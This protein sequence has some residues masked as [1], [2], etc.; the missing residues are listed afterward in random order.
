MEKLSEGLDAM[1]ESGDMDGFLDIYQA[2]RRKNN[3]ENY[4]TDIPL[5]REVQIR[6][7]KHALNFEHIKSNPEHTA[8]VLRDI[9]TLEEM[10]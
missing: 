9:K 7:L 4:G 5:E 2:A 6:Y 3:T 8:E 10:G 1:L